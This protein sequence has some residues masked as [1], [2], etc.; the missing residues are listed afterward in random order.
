MSWTNG[1]CEKTGK[2]VQLQTLQM[3]FYLIDEKNHLRMIQYRIWLERKLR[4]TWMTACPWENMPICLCVV[5]I[6]AA[7]G[8]GKGRFCYDFTQALTD[9][10]PRAP[11]FHCANCWSRGYHS[12]LQSEKQH[13]NSG[14]PPSV[15][16]LGNHQSINL[17]LSF[18]N[19][20]MRFSLVWLKEDTWWGVFFST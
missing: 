7:D 2:D 19:L 14:I 16:S 3:V 17:P 20:K 5:W 1:T 13:L 18:P 4:K 12:S 15:N 9:V 10:L 8:V 11:V 6:A